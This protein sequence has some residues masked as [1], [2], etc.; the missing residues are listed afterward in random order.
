MAN[1]VRRHRLPGE[2]EYDGAVYM[3]VVPKEILDRIKYTFQLRDDDVLLATY[4]K[5]GESTL[6]VLLPP[7]Y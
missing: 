2:Y 4:P 6:K 7:T 1:Q 3:D 5:A